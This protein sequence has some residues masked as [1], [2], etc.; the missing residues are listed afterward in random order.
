MGYVDIGFQ[1]TLFKGKG[2]FRGVWS[3]I[4]KTMQWGGSTDFLS[5]VNLAAMV[6][7]TGC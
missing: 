6:N 7:A 4:F 3:D 5:I 1:K 2:T